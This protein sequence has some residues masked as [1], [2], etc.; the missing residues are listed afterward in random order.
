MLPNFLVIGAR[1]SGTTSIYRNLGAHSEA[2]MHQEI[3]ES[4]FFDRDYKKGID[5]YQQYY[6]SATLYTAIGEEAHACLD[7][8]WVFARIKAYLPK[9]KLIVSLRN[10]V[11]QL[12]S[13]FLKSASKGVLK[14]ELDGLEDLVKKRAWWKTATMWI[15]GGCITRSSAKIELSYFYLRIYGTF[16]LVVLQVYWNS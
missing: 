15:I 1:G 3:K 5:F 16:L 7:T 11:D 4:L 10:P 13:R 2:F 6:L 8:P 14:R 12:H 9:A